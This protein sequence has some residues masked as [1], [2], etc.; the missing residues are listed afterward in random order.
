[1]GQARHKKKLIILRAVFTAFLIATIVFIFANS[2]Q[3]GEESGERSARVMALLN[4]IMDRLGIGFT[5][6]GLLVRKLAHFL[7]Y[8]LLGFWLVLV[9]RVYTRRLLKHLAW[10][11]FFGLLIPV[12]DET[13]QL[14]IPDRSGQLT[15]VLIDFS[16]VL[17][18]HC[19]GLFLVLLLRAFWQEL[20]GEI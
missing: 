6:T 16:G 14:L 5:F 3:I 12:M 17:A 2:A 13:L 18:G 7:E 10:P 20:H 9:L 11:L 4:R 15:D 1:M 19:V 8:M